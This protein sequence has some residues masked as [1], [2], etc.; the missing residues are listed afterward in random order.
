MTLAATIKD[1]ATALNPTGGSDILLSPLGI[2]NGVSSTYVSN[3]TSMLTRRSI[4]FSA[5]DPKVNAASPGGMTQARRK[6]VLYL[7]RVLT[8]GST[9][10][11]TQEK[12]T[13]EA[14]FD[15]SATT[16]QVNNMRY[17]AAQL[18]SDTEFDSFWQAGSLV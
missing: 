2:N 14:N 4:D 6:V 16:A 11:V 13:I 18:L 9:T 10:V 1:G 12:V 7:P 5:K 15:I 8:V 3:D 17:L